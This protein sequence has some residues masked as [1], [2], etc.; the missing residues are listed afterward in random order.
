MVPFYTRI[1]LYT[2]EPM[3][4][5]TMLMNEFDVQLVEQLYNNKWHIYTVCMPRSLGSSPT[6]EEL[7]HDI[8]TLCACPDHWVAHP[9]VRN[10]TMTYIH[11]VCPDYWESHPQEGATP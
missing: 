6:S 4:P 9:L 10:C 8:H 5:V 1:T 11:C 7:Q 3:C 2:K